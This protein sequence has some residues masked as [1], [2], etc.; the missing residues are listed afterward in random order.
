MNLTTNFTNN[1]LFV[2]PAK[3]LF[4]PTINRCVI[5]AAKALWARPLRD[6]GIKI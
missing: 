4:N 3:K 6:A 1:A 5:P 2:I